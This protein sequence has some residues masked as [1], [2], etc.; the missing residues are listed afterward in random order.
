MW[1]PSQTSSLFL[2]RANPTA[3]FLK[4]ATQW[5]MAR[6]LIIRVFTLE[7]EGGLAG[8]NGLRYRP[9]PIGLTIACSP[10]RASRPNSAPAQI[11]NPFPRP[12]RR[13]VRETE[14]PLLVGKQLLKELQRFGGL[15]ALQCKVGNVVPCSERCRVVGAEHPYLLGNQRLIQPQRSLAISHLPCPAS[16]FGPRREPADQ[17]GLR[18]ATKVQSVVRAHAR[19]SRL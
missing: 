18:P 9:C 14:H 19:G 7:S 8:G 16:D 12:E 13:R 15:P 1:P 2:A 10:L 11:I 3:R 5:T 6:S 17:P 4:A